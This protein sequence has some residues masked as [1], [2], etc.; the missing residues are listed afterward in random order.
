MRLY[1][2]TDYRF[3]ELY[4][5]AKRKRIR[6]RFVLT[7]FG[8]SPSYIAVI[9]VTSLY[10]VRQGGPIQELFINIEMEELSSNQEEI[11]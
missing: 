8:F 3:S 4:G 5:R 7:S 11:I 1:R 10:R 9:K 2:R 6:L